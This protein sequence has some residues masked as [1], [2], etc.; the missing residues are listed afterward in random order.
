MFRRRLRELRLP[1]GTQLVTHANPQFAPRF[2]GDVTAFS[3]LMFS[4]ARGTSMNRALIIFAAILTASAL[5]GCS[6]GTLATQTSQTKSAPAQSSIST[7]RA[8]AT[9]SASPVLTHPLLDLS[10]LTG[11]AAKE[12][13]SV[14]HYTVVLKSS[15]G[16]DLPDAAGWTFKSQEPAAGTELPEGSTVTI[17]FAPTPPAPVVVPPAAPN[18]LPAPAPGGGATAKCQDGTISYSAHRQGTCSHHGG[19]AVWY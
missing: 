10:T 5:T 17:T 8:T 2:G 9:P 7:P 3:S 6:S 12:L 19:V 4:R 16:S 14:E 11:A 13:L 15:D 1:A 18:P